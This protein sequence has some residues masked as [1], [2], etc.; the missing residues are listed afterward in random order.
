MSRFWGTHS[1]HFS[2]GGVALLQCRFFRHIRARAI[3]SRSRRTP[4]LHT[5]MTS[6]AAWCALEGGDRKG[7]TMERRVRQWPRAVRGAKAA[8]RLWP[9]G[10]PVKRRCER[11]RTCVGRSAKTEG[12]GTQV[13][14]SLGFTHAGRGED[15]WKNSTHSRVVVVVHRGTMGEGGAVR[16]SDASCEVQSWT[17]KS[18]D[19]E[20]PSAAIWRRQNRD[21]SRSVKKGERDRLTVHSRFTSLFRRFSPSCARHQWVGTPL[22]ANRATR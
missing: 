18:W 15:A 11:H 19:G 22:Q 9:C 6:P 8:A 2:C 13:L 14:S 1:L 21:P 20:R 12:K 7:A 16:A 10:S 17:K 5:L 4:L 3:R